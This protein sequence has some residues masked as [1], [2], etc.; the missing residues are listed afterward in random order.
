[1]KTLA[2]WMAAVGLVLAANLRA[3]EKPG[4]EGWGEEGP[5]KVKGG[6]GLVVVKGGEGGGVGW[7]EGEG[8]PGQPGQPDKGKSKG[9]S[10][11]ERY[12][13]SIDPIVNLTNL[14]KMEITDIIEAR[15][16]AMKDFQAKHAARIQAVTTAVKD[17]YK[18]QNKDAIADAQAEYQELYAPMHQIM[19]KSQ[20]ALD[21]VLTL[22]QKDK[23][24]EARMMEMIKGIIGSIELTDQQLRQVKAICDRLAREEAE[25]GAFSKQN[26]AKLSQAIQEILTPQQKAAIAREQ[27]MNYV[28]KM[29]G[30]A[31]L[32]EDQLRQAEGICDDLLRQQTGK[33]KDHYAKLADAV[34]KMLTDEQKESLANA[35]AG[36]GAGKD[37]GKGFGPDKGPGPDKGFGGGDKGFG[38]EGSP[39]KLPAEPSLPKTKGGEGKP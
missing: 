16:E 25:A 35:R 12:I 28:K 14:Q 7:V 17:A 21:D 30:P 32:T 1:M 5:V 2:L 15:E 31:K 29:Y 36:K 18:T 11:A 27:A 9:K 8:K 38:G 3:G 4:K 34:D 33:S 19:K 26:S 10:A 6:E 23:L 13:E 39:G 24:R 20:A 37:G 22:E